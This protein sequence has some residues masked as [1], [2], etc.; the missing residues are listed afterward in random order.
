MGKEKKKGRA[1]R[2]PNNNWLEKRGLEKRVKESMVL[3][4]SEKWKFT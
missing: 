3:F 4:L 1:Y 2:E